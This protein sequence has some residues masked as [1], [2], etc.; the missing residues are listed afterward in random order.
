MDSTV[1]YLD[2]QATAVGGNKNRRRTDFSC[3]SVYLPVIRN[4]LPEIFD[5]L[6]FTNPHSTTGMRPE[7]TVATQG[8]FILNDPS[9]MDA[10]TATAR[11]LLES[12]QADASPAAVVDRMFAW[13]ASAP[14]T[15]AE[16]ESMLTF[17][18]SMQEQLAAEGAADARLQAWSLACHALFA[19]SRFQ[20]LE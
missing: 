8:L 6:D 14:P 10:A 17:I 4:D 3:R 15:D 11:R 13:I 9:V 16:R 1:W 5:A 12:E 20:I 7:T 2:D 19:S 18:R